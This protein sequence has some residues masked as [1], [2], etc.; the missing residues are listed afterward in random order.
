MCNILSKIYFACEKD[1]QNFKDKY[2]VDDVCNLS[3][4]GCNLIFI[5]ESPY[6]DEVEVKHPLAGKSGKAVSKLFENDEA[7]GKL[8]KEQRIKNIGILN[9]S[10]IPMDITAYKC[11]DLRKGSCVDIVLINWLRKRIGCNKKSIDSIFKDCK[12]EKKKIIE[13]FIKDFRKRIEP[14]FKTNNNNIF[15]PCGNV[16]QAFFDKVKNGFDNCNIRIISNIPHPAR[17]QWTDEILKK[18]RDDKGVKKIIEIN[19]KETKNG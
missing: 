6:T 13:I 3:E 12:E 7:I 11:S 14:L 16:A 15:V 4:T 17:N 18:L 9:V 2:L 19:N 5:L 10:N 8:I 1:R